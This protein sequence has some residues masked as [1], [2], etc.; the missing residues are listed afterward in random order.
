MSW[1]AVNI[2]VRP[3]LINPCEFDVRIAQTCVD[4]G[5]S[6]HFVKDK[7]LVLSLWLPED[8]PS[9]LPNGPTHQVGVGTLL[10]RPSDPS[11]MLVVQEI[12]GP[13]TNPLLH[14]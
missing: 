10:L 12:T 4:T 9:R 7:L 13:G 8:G 11:Q 6:F 14:L 2:S 3:I 5:F 1:L